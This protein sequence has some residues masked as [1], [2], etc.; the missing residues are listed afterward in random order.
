MIQGKNITKKFGELSVLQGVDISIAA[1]EVVSLVGPSGSGKSTLLHILGTL[2]RPDLGSVEIQG[3]E[4]TKLSR[5]ELAAFRNRSIGFV[6]Q[7][8]HLLPEF[9]ALENVCIPGWLGKR[10]KTE[11]KREGAA[12]L[13]LMG[14][15]SRAD[16]RPNQLSG[17]EQQRVAVARALINKPAVIF[18]DEPTGN[19]DTTTA[20]E[21]H[22][23]FFDLRDQFKQTFLIVTHN[24]ELAALSDRCLR[25]RDGHLM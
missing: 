16:H 20:G 23:L 5:N 6:F 2:D 14:L 8:H 10:S 9:S 17:G 11:V 1:G 13:E 24:E 12:L 3:T 22:R 21:L 19:L 4:V 25:I 7:F 15:S 18:A